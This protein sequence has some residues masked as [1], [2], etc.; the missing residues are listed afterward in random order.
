MRTTA[1]EDPSTVGSPF[2]IATRA[3]QL[4]EPFACATSATLYVSERDSV[5]EDN[6]KWLFFGVGTVLIK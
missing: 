3:L 1:L 5:Y 4:D 2:S 6:C